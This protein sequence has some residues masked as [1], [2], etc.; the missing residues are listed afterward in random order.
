MNNLVDLLKSIFGFAVILIPLLIAIVQLIN[1]HAGKTIELDIPSLKSFYI[2]R[3]PVDREEWERISRRHN[4]IFRTL[5]GLSMGI[6]FLI[7]GLIQMNIYVSTILFVLWW[8]SFIIILYRGESHYINKFDFKKGRYYLFNR[9]II[10]IEA[11]YQ[12]L[13]S[14]C[15]QSLK[16]MDYI[17]AE[18]NQDYGTLEAYQMQSWFLQRPRQIRVQIKK[19]KDSRSSFGILLN[20]E[21]FKT[22]YYWERQKGKPQVRNSL[23]LQ[24]PNL[25]A[26]SKVVNQFINLLI[27]K[28]KNVSDTEHSKKEA[29]E[30]NVAFD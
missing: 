2:K 30:T 26:R 14:K 6:V 1:T 21:I 4:F 9:E 25:T 8:I 7:F 11:E 12:Y 5:A 23:I 10:L 27:S 24:V 3:I 29:V 28:P 16:D 19:V 20:F 17:I 18:A 15:Y 22:Y 13:F